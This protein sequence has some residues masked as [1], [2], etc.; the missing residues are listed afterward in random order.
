[1]N[2][3]KKPSPIVNSSARPLMNVDS[4][5]L[6]RDAGLDYFLA[7]VCANACAGFSGANPRTVKD[8]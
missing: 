7:S 8:G 1:M 3:L 2:G 6:M 4:L 5:P